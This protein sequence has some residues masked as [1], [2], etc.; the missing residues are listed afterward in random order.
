MT[1]GPL[2]ADL[3]KSGG[4][5]INRRLAPPGPLHDQGALPSLGHRPDRL[6]L[7]LSEHGRR[8][9]GQ[10]SQQIP[11]AG[12]EVVHLVQGIAGA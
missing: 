3:I 11:G 1:V 2:P 4:E 7:T 10:P 9:S 5:Q 8:V 6:E 12:F